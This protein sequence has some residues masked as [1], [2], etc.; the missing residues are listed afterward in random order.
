MAVRRKNI[1]KKP[2]AS[3]KKPA[4]VKHAKAKAGVGAKNKPAKS[5]AAVN[6]TTKT[7]AKKSPVNK[8]RR[9]E[10]QPVA[11]SAGR[12][13][14]GVKKPASK[15]LGRKVKTLTG[16]WIGQLGIIVRQDPVIGTYFI[17]FDSCQRDPI[18]KSLE[19]GPYFESQLEF[20]KT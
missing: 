5:K 15:N 9:T 16:R 1:K 6:K 3:G 20:L 13:Q 11:E 12:S 7:P 4:A 19:W 10:K 18:Y 14:S 17:T 2:S 8:K